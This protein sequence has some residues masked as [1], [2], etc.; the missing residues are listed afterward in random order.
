LSAGDAARQIVIKALPM[1]VPESLLQHS[2]EKKRFRK[3]ILNEFDEQKIFEKTLYLPYLDFTYHYVAEKGFLS[4]RTAQAKGRSIML[5][6]REVDLDFYPELSALA[7]L[8]M[9]IR[10]NSDS[11]VQ[12]VDSTVLVR[13]RLEDLKEMLSNYDNQLLELAKQYDS[14]PQTDPM[15]QEV[16]DNIDHLHRTRENRWRMFADGL[17]MPSRMDLETIEFLEGSL[18]YMPYFIVRFV[19][20]GESRF[21]VWDREGKPNE[22]IADELMRNG[23][24][25]ELILSHATV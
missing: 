19:R 23:K 10:F 11:V 18:F 16:K 9:D 22:P 21:L 15:R 1:L 6:L 17:N 25:R 4:K 13:E 2:A 5:A 7:P 8:M 14:M 12:G 20:G 24:F 3:G